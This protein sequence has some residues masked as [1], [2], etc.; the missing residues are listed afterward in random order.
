MPPSNPLAFLQ[1]A[2]DNLAAD[3]A[4]YGPSGI[5]VDEQGNKINPLGRDIDNFLRN[6]LGGEDVGGKPTPNLGVLPQ[7]PTQQTGIG[8]VPQPATGAPIFPPGL[9]EGPSSTFD[10]SANP[11]TPAVNPPAAIDPSIA[12]PGGTVGQQ[13]PPS[14][15]DPLEPFGGLG[16]DGRTQFPPG[17]EGGPVIP[18]TTPPPVSNPFNRT[19]PGDILSGVG[20]NTEVDRPYGGNPRTA[21]ATAV[22]APAAA[23]FA[24]NPITAATVLNQGVRTGRRF[25]DSS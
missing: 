4:K 12:D 1:Q 11:F 7:A 10:D 8:R 14:T 15:A 20:L 17:S 2:A 6:L 19:G 24:M 13:V 25:F 23:M 9:D 16:P 5:P 3:Q 18:P 22:A 21:G